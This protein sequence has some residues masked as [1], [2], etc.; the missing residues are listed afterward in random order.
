MP[1]ASA[2]PESN[3]P[4]AFSQFALDLL[5]DL[6]EPM[7]TIRS[8]ASVLA[9]KGRRVDDDD[10]TR[11]LT[12]IT[13]AAKRMQRLIDDTVTFASADGSLHE[14]HQVNVE[15]VLRFAL[16]NL[17]AAICETN[18]AVT[19]D[20]LPTIAV[21]FGDLA[22]VFQN[23]IANAIEY[24]ADDLPR[25]HIGCSRSGPDWVFSVAD[26]GIGIA[27]KYQEQVF[28]PFK[29]LHSEQEHPGTGLGLAICRRIVESHGGRMWLESAP[30][31]GS[32]FYF[33][34][35]ERKESRQSAAHS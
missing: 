20:P 12:D 32:K 4:D 26:N 15:E 30:T 2:V 24:H 23:L 9:Q 5:H 31:A 18:A 1:Y 29:R 27:P 22:R 33:T 16:S 11:L 13:E 3:V 28:A 6:R 35:T 34:I 25:I 17:E 8:F 14:Q 10:T 7:R 19:I 21:N